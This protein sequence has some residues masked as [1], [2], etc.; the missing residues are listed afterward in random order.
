[1][2]AVGTNAVNFVLR[3]KKNEAPRFHKPFNARRIAHN[4][5]VRATTSKEDLEQIEETLDLSTSGTIDLSRDEYEKLNK[6][7]IW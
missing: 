1:M 4:L 3:P 5:W 7:T 2:E 6:R